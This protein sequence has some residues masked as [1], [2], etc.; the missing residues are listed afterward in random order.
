M[1]SISRP[2]FEIGTTTN[3]GQICAYYYRYKQAKWFYEL[4][5]SRTPIFKCEDDLELVDA[6]L[7]SDPKP[8][9]ELGETLGHYGIIT[10]ILHHSDSTYSYYLTD[11][12]DTPYIHWVHQSGMQKYV[13]TIKV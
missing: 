10:G 6:A 5:N 3:H 8:D 4:G 9:F 12:C 7:D 1:I 13:S 2:K 11:G